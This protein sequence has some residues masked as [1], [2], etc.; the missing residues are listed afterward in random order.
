MSNIPTGK[1]IYLCTPSL[2]P[3]TVLNG[4]D[5]ESANYSEHLR[6]YSSL[7]FD[8]YENI[9]VDGKQVRSNGYDLL[10]VYMN[11][12][13]EDIAYF[14]MQYP[15]VQ[16]DGIKEYKSIVAYSIDKE[17][18]DKDW[19]NFKVNTGEKDSLEQ[20]VDNNTDDLGFTINF[21]DFYN[22][23]RKDL[24]L[25]HIILE[26][27]PNWSVDDND[28][29]RALWKKR[30]SISED[31]INLYALMT[32]VI[33]PNAECIFV[34]DCLNRKIK[35]YSKSNL[36][37][38]TNI[39]IGFRNLASNIEQS[40]NEDSVFTRFNVAGG[41][42]LEVNDWNFNNGRIFNLDY[43]MHEPYMTQNQVAKFRAW[44]DWQNEHREEFANLSQDVSDLEAKIYD[45]KYRLPDDGCEID[46][47][48]NM[49]KEGLEESLK[50]YQ[51][52]L[53]AFGVSVDENPT[54]I[55]SDGKTYHVLIEEDEKGNKI[56]T[57]VD[58]NNIPIQADVTL[59]YNAWE[60]TEDGETHV[61]YDRYLEILYGMENGK[62]GYYTYYEIVKYIIPNIEIALW[63]LEHVEIKDDEKDYNK[64]F[65]TKWELYGL[66]EL[67][68]RL[69]DYQNRVDVLKQYSTYPAYFYQIKRLDFWEM[70]ALDSFKVKS[71]E[72]QTG[73]N[74]YDL[75]DILAVEG[76]N[77]VGF[78]VDDENK[79]YV[80]IYSKDDTLLDTLFSS[81]ITS[82]SIEAMCKMPDSS[83]EET[84]SYYTSTSIQPVIVGDFA[85]DSQWEKLYKEYWEKVNY[86]GDE[87]T[88]NTIKWWIKELEAQIDEVGAEEQGYN[89]LRMQMVA[90][91]SMYETE[92]LESDESDY[93]Y[94]VVELD[95]P[96]SEWGFTIDDINLFHTLMHDTDY[97]NENILTTSLNTT[98]TLTSTETIIQKEKE[99]YDDAV[100]KLSEIS[101]PQITFSVSMDNIMQIKEFER[102]RE[103]CSLLRFIRLGIRDD[104]SV[105][106]RIVGR[107][108]N[109]CDITDDFTLEFSNM[110]TSNSGRSDLTELLNNTS[111]NA[112]KNSISL[113]SGNSESDKEYAANLL[114][115]MVSSG[116][117]SSA[118]SG[119][120]GSG[121]SVDADEVNELIED[122]LYSNVINEASFT[123]LFST[124]IDVEKLVA[125][126]INTETLVADIIRGRDDDSEYYMNMLTGH[127]NM[128]TIVGN[129]IFSDRVSTLISD[130]AI[131]NIDIG[132]FKTLV[133]QNIGVADLQA[134]DII[135]S[136]NMRILSEEDATEGMIMSGSEIQFLDGDGNP[137]ISIG[138]N[139]ISDG[140][141]GTIVDYDHPAI[142][143]KDEN[144]QIML[145]SQ[146]LE[147]TDVGLAPMIQ[148]NSIGANKLSF[149][150]IKT[151]NGDI[152][153]SNYNGDG[154][155]WGQVITEFI[156]D[157]NT[158]IE[159]A[160]TA[161]DGTVVDTDIYFICWPYNDNNNAPSKDDE[162]WDTNSPQWNP[163]EY[164][165][166]MTVTTFGDGTV[167]KTNPV[168]IQ[169]AK[170]DSNLKVEVTSSNGNIF[171]G[172]NIATTL[173]CNVYYGTT[174]VTN[175]VTKFVW[176]KL[177]KNGNVDSDWNR[178][179]SANIIY[180]TNADVQERA[181]FECAVEIDI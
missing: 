33:A 160:N 134:G 91:V 171:T 26:K 108:W 78:K 20:L 24:S 175:R 165:W 47:W 9:V 112:G 147:E 132:Y 41:N 35:A 81:D 120:I 167:E 39:F 161:L 69:E 4:I 172:N 156:S 96:N 128:D 99:L 65:E 18:E 14:Q 97:T 53:N 145:N 51:S 3:I 180:L 151:E 158:A 179:T 72:I 29:D 141:G 118:V 46:Q 71:I 86:I 100:E 181:S 57:I 109:P 59:T 170:G 166:Q 58:E 135:L 159:D 103:D 139:T 70:Y 106:L 73:G 144:G 1:K 117:F 85:G 42:N 6:D 21:I 107:S 146:G 17:W 62:A 169:A 95:E 2:K 67:K 22:P 32:S 36:E 27:M 149:D 82:F 68:G 28:I 63:N 89:L 75:D 23:D 37:F 30:L 154:N 25:I 130:T 124:Y 127:L 125:D 13:L 80:G 74:T 92:I 116:I 61:D 153:V 111:G 10:D 12:Y 38:D 168:C 56:R 44:I 64:E 113:G 129:Q 121:S 122:Y 115:L 178:A 50:Y 66:E 31:S 104:Y 93:G 142:I 77:S 155:T 123:K 173:T 133:S 101:Q 34:F 7:T 43:F 52:L 136:N 164:I 55:G 174:D 150:F 84:V 177:D 76:V 152:V 8:V 90:K 98:S 131:S 102:L 126:S 54:Y 87:E 157:T 162:G 79:L 137:S 45:L 19:V 5:T 94:D 11:L 119:A 88:E 83:Y 138:Y 143:I 110:I 60:I 16:N 48:K 15:Q 49:N 140:E 163:G 40:V 114:A 176:S 148:N 105:K